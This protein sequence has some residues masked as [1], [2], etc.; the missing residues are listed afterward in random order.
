MQFKSKQFKMNYK[1][2]VEKSKKNSNWRLNIW[3]PRMRRGTIVLTILMGF[4]LLLSAEDSFQQ[5]DKSKILPQR[6]PLN[7]ELFNPPDSKFGL[8]FCEASQERLIRTAGTDDEMTGIAKDNALRIGAG[9]TF[10]IVMK[11]MF[12]INVL[13]AIK[14]CQ[15]VCRIFCA[16]AN[17]VQVILA[18]TEQ[19]RGMLGVIDGFSPQ[20][21][22]SEKEVNERMTLLRK[23]GYKVG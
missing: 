16:T 14:E 15:E 7:P 22:E 1:K 12:P 4:I 19:G 17:P 11:D 23:F 2:F 8:A 10:I 5:Q 20:G 18:E 9:H 21:V 6:C 3:S 13:N